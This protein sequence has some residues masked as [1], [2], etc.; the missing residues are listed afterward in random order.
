MPKQDAI[1]GK[2]C[3]NV[4]YLSILANLLKQ[5]ELNGIRITIKQRLRVKET[6]SK[7]AEEYKIAGKMNYDANPTR[8]LV[9]SC[10]RCKINPEKK[11]K[12]S[13]A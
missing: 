7:H 1:K 12:A 5:K 9:T 3:T 13:L 10:A 6:Y 4:D 2:T 11:K 8:M